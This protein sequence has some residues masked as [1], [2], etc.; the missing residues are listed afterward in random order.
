MNRIRELRKQ[1]NI[2]MK[3]LGKKIGVSESTI[4]LY[5]NGKH[6]PDNNM[7]IALADYF[8][9]SIDYL[10]YHTNVRRSVTVTVIN[11]E[12]GDITSELVEKLVTMMLSLSPDDQQRMMDYASVLIAARKAPSAPQE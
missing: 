3:E 9:V 6:A 1:K 11:K 5:E 8:D 12:P 2:T 7:L 4:S 10:L